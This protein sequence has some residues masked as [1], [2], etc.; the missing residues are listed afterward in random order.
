[1]KRLSLA[2]AGLVGAIG[3]AAV[4]SQAPAGRPSSWGDQHDGTYRN[5]I[6][7]AD[8]SDPDA[9]RVGDDFYL[10]AS[11]FHFIG[12]QVLH[13][14][15]LVNWEIIGQVF[16][17]LTMH[18]KYDA[19]G[20][21]AEGTWAPTIRYHAGTFYIFVCTPHD[22]LFMWQAKDPAGPWSE[23]RT[24]RLVDRWEDPC[25]FWD[26]D[27]RAYLVHSYLGAGPLILHQMSP[28]GTRLLDDGVEIYRGPV[29]EGPKLFKR[30]DWYYISLPEGGVSGGGQTVLRARDVH[31]PY[32]RREVLPPGSPHQ[33][34]LV[35][36]ANG[37]WWFLAFKSTGYLGRVTHLMPVTW[38]ADD[39]PVFG[40][41]GRTVEQWTKPNV[42]RSH[43]IR[44]PARS[45]TFEGRALSA[46]WQ[47]NHNPIDASWSLTE[48]P[49]WLRLK[50]LPA[51]GLASARNTL[52]QKLWGQAGLIEVKLD[53]RALAE[54]QHAGLA[55]MSGDV[56]DWVGV[57]EIDGVRR[58]AWNG[59]EGPTL[60]GGDV[61]LRGT[62]SGPAARLLY[63][64]DGKTYTDRGAAV[65]LKF[66][67]WKGARMALFSYGPNPGI[68][69]VDDIQYTLGE[70]GAKGSPSAASEPDI[71]PQAMKA[72]F[73][74]WPAGTSPR[75]IGT[76]VAENFVARPFER[77][78]GFIIYPEVCA[79]YGALTVASLT[80]NTNLR[81]RL[82]RKFEPLL[83]PEGSSH[84]SPEAHVDFRVFGAVP[85][86]IFRQTGDFR[87]LDL[88]KSL[89]D[90]QWETTTADGI[91]SEARYWIDDMYMITA[92]QVQAYRAT[93]DAKY[94]ERTA[95][96]MVAYLDR[97]QQPNG[98]FFHAPDSP[99]YW[100]RGN[101]WMAA[102]AAE[103]L[104]SLPTDYPTRPRI[105]DGYRKMMARLLE[106]QGEDGL[107]RQ[108]I[109]HPESWPET[110]G[111][112][113]FAFAMITGVKNG[114][115]DPKIYGPVARKAWLGLTG[116]LDANGN[117]GNVCEGTPKG[118]S[119]EYYLNRRRNVGDLHGQAPVLWSASALLR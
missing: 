6:L 41:H 111:T 83:T 34:A 2:V 30:R 26:D 112:G 61:W 99:F 22:G 59:G 56:F 92:L 19:M 32:E 5:P 113:M 16:H 45:D 71:G 79:W 108:L 102:G 104:R 3:V 20:A 57:T 42:G 96:A 48:R 51:A 1:M 35:E 53:V 107:W 88:G 58:I 77:P 7:P 25:P 49:G 98:L 40:D 33:G 37:D 55:F 89:A 52:T 64:L 95:R 76:R 68:A 47:W 82:V 63:S 101:G 87:Y 38:G 60:P 90:K 27:G 103:L 50:A 119:V 97:L 74:N 69:D 93:G 94:I 80:G 39:W 18:P 43:P 13:S 10:V 116:H 62:V 14:R 28:D 67:K 86:E 23:T 75:E 118:P 65:E 81:T 85:L 72:D 17:R 91:T 15:D 100:S 8:F 70:S 24:V 11:D 117:I 73:A 12:M 109:D 106:Y 115:L 78:T 36:L 54:G 31:G 66:A 29:A 46:N 21:Y 9:I 105:L 44:Q 114:W 110:S 4:A 84:I